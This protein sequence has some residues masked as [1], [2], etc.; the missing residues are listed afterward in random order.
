MVRALG[1]FLSVALLD[2]KEETM[3][4]MVTMVS[5]GNHQSVRSMV[6]CMAPFRREDAHLIAQG[7]CGTVV[8]QFLDLE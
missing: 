1:F 8:S 3:E 5:E 6:R 7:F 2:S 4:R